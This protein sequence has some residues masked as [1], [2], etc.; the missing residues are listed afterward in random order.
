MKIFNQLYPNN[1]YI[2]N[3]YNKEYQ[4]DT[5]LIAP[6][7]Y[8]ITNLNIDNS[9][10]TNKVIGYDIVD[11]KGNIVSSYIPL[12]DSN[13]GKIEA[14]LIDIFT[15]E[16][17]TE[18][19]TR[20]KEITLTSGTKLKIAD[21]RNTFAAKL[22]FGRLKDIWDYNR[23]IPNENL[24]Q[25]DP[26]KSQQSNSFEQF[27]QSLNKPNTNPIL[28]GNQQEQAKKFAELQERLNN[29]EFIEGAK[30]AYESSKALS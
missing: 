16:N 21:W 5:W 15:Y 17:I 9:K 1:K 2:R 18:E 27:Q 13:T 10:N 26:Q 14:K 8:E 6:E 30:N 20:N 19:K 3:I 29:K 4:T 28:Q 24:F 11:K 23:F 7:G 22:E 25:I 12:S